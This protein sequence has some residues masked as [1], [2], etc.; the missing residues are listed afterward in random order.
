VTPESEKEYTA[1]QLRA[2]LP[3]QDVDREEMWVKMRERARQQDQDA[4][5][6]TTKPNP[7]DFLKIELEMKD[8]DKFHWRLGQLAFA[9]QQQ[10][11][12]Y[13]A[14]QGVSACLNKA[15]W[16]HLEVSQEK[17]QGTTGVAFRTM[18]WKE[19]CHSVIN[20]GQMPTGQF[21]DGHPILRPFADS[22][23]RISYTKTFLRGFVD[24]RLKPI[25]QP[26]NMKQ[27]L[28]HFDKSYGFFYAA[29]LELMGVRD[30]NAE[31]I[32]SHIGR[33]VGLT[34]HCV[35]LWK[36][37]AKLGTTMIPADICADNGVSVGLL[38]HIHLSSRDSGVRK[39]LYDVMCQ[40]KAEMEHVRE[41]ISLYPTAAWPLLYES[42]LPNYYLRFLLKHKFDVSK[43]YTD[44]MIYSPGLV[45]YATKK[46]WKWQ[47]TH[48]VED[49][50]AEEAPF[51]LP[52]MGL[53]M[54]GSKYKSVNFN[55][56]R[57]P[58]S[59]DLYPEAEL[60]ARAN[61]R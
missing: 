53:L 12:D 5:N 38:R 55:C 16:K 14:L 24:A 33:A 23:K 13:Y 60:D 27:L 36:K 42:F 56:D 48:R 9:D 32:A 8:E 31:H 18:F 46:G 4:M 45:W 29:Q 7:V 52:G 51:P 37:Y 6:V 41:L 47:R 34:Q 20:T 3:H 61:R 1:E 50:V 15:R 35:L 19:A 59:N 58:P 57:T 26:G 28:E 17:G 10:R 39:C 40:V 25:S 43:Y 30:E 22:F 44:E 11:R 2:Q 21:V 49:L 54:R